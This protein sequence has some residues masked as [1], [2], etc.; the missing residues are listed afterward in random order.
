MK[1]KKKKRKKKKEKVLAYNNFK[2][3]YPIIGLG[4]NEQ[5]ILYP[6]IVKKGPGDRGIV[7]NK[8]KHTD[9]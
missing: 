8:N 6:I 2:N 9:F 4:K 5:G 3:N 1:E 7:I